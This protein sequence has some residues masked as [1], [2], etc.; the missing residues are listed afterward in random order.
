VYDIRH[1]LCGQLQNKIFALN[2]LCSV[3]DKMS[4]VINFLHITYH[5]RWSL[6]T[7]AISFKITEVTKYGQ[8][9]YL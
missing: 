7:T 9:L 8:G 4:L 3:G 5:F 6:S 2:Y 1:C